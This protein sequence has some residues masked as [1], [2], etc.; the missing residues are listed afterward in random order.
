MLMKSRL[1]CILFGEKL[2]N[3]PRNHRPWKSQHFI[4]NA[5]WAHTHGFCFMASHKGKS[6]CI[7]WHIYEHRTHA[8]PILRAVN[9]TA[10]SFSGG[11]RQKSFRTAISIITSR[12][13]KLPSPGRTDQGPSWILKGEGLGFRLYLVLCYFCVLKLRVRR[14][15]GK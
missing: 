8:R 14:G 2:W 15:N 1:I 7:S 5:P 4:L 12:Q 13:G 3:S 10:H 9:C 11:Q 6:S